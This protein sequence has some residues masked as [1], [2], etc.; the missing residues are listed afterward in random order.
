MSAKWSL[1]HMWSLMNKLN[2]QKSDRLKD[3]EQMTA[4][5]REV[6]GEGLSEKEKGLVD[7]DVSVVTAGGNSV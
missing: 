6:D 7:M 2:M 3:G 4:S 1:N 5:R